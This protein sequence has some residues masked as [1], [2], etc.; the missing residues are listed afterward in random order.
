MYVYMLIFKPKIILLPKSIFRPHNK[1][2]FTYINIGL[3]TE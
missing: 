2:V 1:P 3:Y